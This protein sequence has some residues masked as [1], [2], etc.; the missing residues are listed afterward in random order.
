V[1]DTVNESGSCLL[2][3]EVTPNGEV[4]GVSF[5]FQPFSKEQ[6]SANLNRAKIARKLKFIENVFRLRLTLPENIT[7]S[8]VQYIESIFRGITEGEFLTRGNGI[9]IFLKGYDVDVSKP[10]FSECGPF[11]YFFGTEQALLYPQAV[12][13]VGPYYVKLKRALIANQRNIH[14]LREGKD[15]WVRFEVLD[16]QIT[17]HYERYTRPDTH[18]RIRQKL[19]D[20]HTQLLK[21]ESE[22]L[23]DTL[24]QPLI[25]DLPAVEAVKIGSGWLEYHNF[26]DRFSPQEPI[27]DETRG[28]WRLPIYIVYAS[29]EGAPVGELLIDLRTGSIIDEPSPELMYQQG[30]ALGKKVLRVV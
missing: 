24:L 15:L 1:L 12:L 11:Q 27:L 6:A 5:G 17:Y 20:F 7:P 30:L 3:S 29:G 10:P 21:E 22:G 23:A 4:L 2:A 19:E 8:H 25:L 26:P 13:D 18:K 14:P 9:T 28:C 16:G